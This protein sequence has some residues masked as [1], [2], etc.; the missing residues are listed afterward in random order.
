MTD[1]VALVIPYIAPSALPLLIVVIV[2]LKIKADRGKTSEKRDRD[3]L[4]LHD[5]ILKH[6]FVIQ[7]LKDS[8]SLMATVQEDIR[9][10]LGI[11]NTSVAKLDTNVQNLTEIVRE[12]KR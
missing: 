1:L 5:K 3:S 12:L 9:S 7:S 4:E 10:E 8:Q 6:D 11:L 2:Y